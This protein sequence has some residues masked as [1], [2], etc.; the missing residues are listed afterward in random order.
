MFLNTAGEAAKQFDIEIHA[1]CLMSNHYHLLIKTPRANLG[2]AMRHINGVYTQR[3]NRSKNTDGALFRGRY[4]SILVDSDAYLLHLSKY[5]HL[6]PIT[7]GLVAKLEDYSWSSYLTYIDEN[8]QPPFWLNKSE[9]Y[10]QITNCLDKANHYRLFMQNKELDEG[11]LNF[12]KKERLVPVLGN[13]LF[14]HGLK[15]KAP[16]C[17]VPRQERICNKPSITAIIREV[18]CV[19]DVSIDSL[20][21]PKKGRGCKNIPRKIAM[22]LAQKV[23]DYRLREIAAVFGLAH[24]GGVSHAIN[25][26]VDILTQH[27]PLPKNM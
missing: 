16:S 9:I 3:Y 22:Y 19:F 2:R 24:Y 21:H 7:A 12:Y 6:N 8:I 20:I 1:Y 5:I 15:L 26:V 27:F 14:V 23:G 25:C 17:E 10:D 11:L 18:V 4:K 13:E